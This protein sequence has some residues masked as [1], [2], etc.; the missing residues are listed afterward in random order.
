MSH[1]LLG[2][3]KFYEFFGHVDAIRIRIHLLCHEI[4]LEIA[5]VIE[6]FRVH[7]EFLASDLFSLLEV[8]PMS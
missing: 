1:I 3:R 2:I 7:G 8:G 5:N 4:A 6:E